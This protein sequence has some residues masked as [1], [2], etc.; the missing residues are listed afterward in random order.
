MLGIIYFHRVGCFENRFQWIC[1]WSD[2]ETFSDA[3]FQP[4]V[5]DSATLIDVTEVVKVLKFFTGE[6]FI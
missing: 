4:L 6:C 2:G 5:S 1:L 3:V